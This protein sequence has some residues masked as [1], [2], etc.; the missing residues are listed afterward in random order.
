MTYNNDVHLA[1]ARVPAHA[2]RDTLA[3]E[4]EVRPLLYDAFHTAAFRRE[5]R[6]KSRINSTSLI[7]RYPLSASCAT[8]LFLYAAAAGNVDIVAFFLFW[9]RP[10]YTE[11]VFIKVGIVTPTPACRSRASV[12]KPTCK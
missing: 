10:Q 7:A 2:R 9:G 6:Q 3:N 4:R 12:V 5:A 11:S 8:A 1:A